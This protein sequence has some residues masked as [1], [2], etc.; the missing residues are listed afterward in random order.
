MQGPV[1][2]GNFK[3]KTRFIKAQNSLRSANS[4]YMTSTVSGHV[5][6]PYQRMSNGM[7]NDKLDIAGLDMNELEG[8]PD[9]NR[10][11]VF[12]DITTEIDGRGYA[13]SIKGLGARTPLYD[14]TPSDFYFSNKKNYRSNARELTNELWFGEAPYGAQGEIS[15]NFDLELTGLAKGCNINGFYICPVIEVNEFP[16]DIIKEQAGKFWYRRYHGKYMQEQRLVPSN[17]RLY[18]QSKM[19]LGQT[20]AG[21]LKAFGIYSEEQIDTFIDNYISSGIAALTLFART[22][23]HGK[24]GYEGLDYVNVWLDKDSLLASDG[25]IH[26]VDIEGLDWVSTGC[27]ISVENRINSQFNRNYYEFMYGLD[28][29]LRHRFLL[30]NTYKDVSIEDIRSTLAVRFEMALGKDPFIELKNSGDAVDIVI[31]PFVREVS[32]VTVRLVDLR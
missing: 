9:D 2:I 31:L 20:T 21:V 11:M 17:I 3:E 12:P 10:S 8:I 15:A 26:F 4:N 16:E 25:T 22:L 18:H 13:L 23:R 7:E 27:E 5:F 30:M 24:Y 14:S 1:I 29:L 6:L 28:A 32:P 19:I